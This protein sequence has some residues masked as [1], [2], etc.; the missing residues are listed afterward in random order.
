MEDIISQKYQV[1]QSE[2]NERQ[3]RLWAASEAM[4]LGHG[5]ISLV[6]RVNGIRQSSRKHH[7]NCKGY[8]GTAPL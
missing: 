5:G 3:K 8:F 7:G 4:C 2:W 1:L 6:S